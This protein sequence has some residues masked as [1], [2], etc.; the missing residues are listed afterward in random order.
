LHATPFLALHRYK[1]DG[2]GGE[3]T[4]FVVAAEFWLSTSGWIPRTIGVERVCNWRAARV[5]PNVR[6]EFGEHLRNGAFVVGQR[7]SEELLRNARR[8]RY[9][10][11]DSLRP[12]T[13]QAGQYPIT[14][15]TAVKMPVPI[16]YIRR[17]GGVLSAR[18]KIQSA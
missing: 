16:S 9:E 8:V 11:T 17:L 10:R 15:V 4:Q 7:G 5:A 1:F 12:A 13:A 18:V 6:R 2:F 14:P 3:D